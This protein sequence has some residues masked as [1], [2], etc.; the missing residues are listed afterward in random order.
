MA[1]AI[2]HP[3]PSGRC[4]VPQTAHSLQHRPRKHR[5]RLYAQFQSAH[6][7]MQRAAGQ[8]ATAPS[9]TASLIAAAQEPIAAAPKQQTGN[10]HLDGKLKIIGTVSL[11][12]NP[13]MCVW[14]SRQGLVFARCLCV[15]ASAADVSQKSKTPTA[16][17]TSE[18]CSCA[19]LASDSSYFYDKR[20]CR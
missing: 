20:S 4:H 15:L 19:L 13:F 14:T 17:A 3:S 9:H 10:E 18:L 1:Q 2:C 5:H 7:T 16:L 12:L 11:F 8:H 6:D